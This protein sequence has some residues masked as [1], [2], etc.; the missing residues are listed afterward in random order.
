M[1]GLVIWAYYSAM[2]AWISF[3]ASL[4][5]SI[6]LPLSLTAA[7]TSINYYYYYYQGP[8][9]SSIKLAPLVCMRPNVYFEDYV[10]Q[11]DGCMLDT[12]RRLRR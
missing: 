1:Y 5:Q 2:D 6:S 12:D 3:Q 10:L 9:T 11:W 8:Y 4:I 7:G